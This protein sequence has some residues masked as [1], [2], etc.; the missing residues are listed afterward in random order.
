M[1]SYLSGK[2]IDLDSGKCTILLNTGI[3]YEINI[4][5]ITYSK[6]LLGENNSLYIFH[7]I[8]ENSQSLYGFLTKEEK[9]MFLEFTKVSGVGGR[10]GLNLLDLGIGNIINA[11]INDDVAFF[12]QAKGIGK[13]TAEKIFLEIK[14]KDFINNSTKNNL[15]TEVNTKIQKDNKEKQIKASLVSIGYDSFIIDDILKNLPHDLNEIGEIIQYV[16]KN[17]K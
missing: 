13:K 11:V 9:N 15:V 12:A 17:I 5:D 14:D 10:S 3:G 4:N 6:L 2:V 16:V 8:T 1:I 7:N